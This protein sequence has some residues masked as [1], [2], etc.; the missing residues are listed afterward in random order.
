MAKLRVCVNG[1]GTIGKRVAEA[2]SLQADMVV[3]GVVKTKADYSCELIREKGYPLYAA[4][5]ESLESFKKANIDVEG[6]AEDLFKM[7][8]V[9]V[10]CTPE[11]VGAKYKQVYDQLGVKAIFQ[12]GEKHELVDASFVAEV[13]YE[14]ALNKRFIR[15]VSCNTTG[16]SRTI[17]YLDKSFGVRK[18]RATIIR[19]GADPSETRKGPIN[20]LVPNPAKFPSH[21]GPDVQTILPHVEVVTGAVVAPTTLMHV[22]VVNAELKNDASKEEI[23]RCFS[24]SKRIRLIDAGKGL[25]STA[26]IIEYAR[27][28]G[29]K[30]GDLPEVAVWSDSI[31]LV[32]REVY[33]IQAVH[34]E[35]I[36][37]PENVDAVR[38]AAGSVAEAAKS[39]TLTNQSLGLV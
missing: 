33:Y 36:V 5:K 16:L 21:H 29:R 19:R 28:L 31:Y 3:E 24:R 13:N 9:V 14:K 25:D 39:V 17:G 38:A 2:L 34:Q 37:V 30:R 35:S 6:L 18:V 32:G 11:G 1:Y 20:A 22:H 12:G 8:D 10:D 4:S 27:D 7:C 15:V 26:A 23:I